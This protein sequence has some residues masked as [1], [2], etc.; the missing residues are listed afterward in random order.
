MRNKQSESGCQWPVFR[1]LFEEKDWTS[2]DLVIAQQN[3]LRKSIETRRIAECRNNTIV[4]F[5]STGT[6]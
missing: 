1:K 4:D 3:G 2:N 5:D 6:L